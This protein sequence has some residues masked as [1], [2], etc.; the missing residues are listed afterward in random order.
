MHTYKRRPTRCLQPADIDNMCFKGAT[1]LVHIA[2]ENN[3]LSVVKWLLVNERTHTAH[4]RSEDGL[5]PYNLACRV[6]T[7]NMVELFQEEGA[8]VVDK[9]VQERSEWRQV[10]T[11]DAS[12]SSLARRS[13][14]QNAQRATQKREKRPKTREKRRILARVSRKQHILANLARNSVF[15]RSSLANSVFRSDALAHKPC[16][17]PI[18]SR[19]AFWRELL[20]L[21]LASLAGTSW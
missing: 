6:D 2:E 9:Y 7:G 14:N 21:T 4:H 3:S 1:N 19:S 10:E 15:W 20:S 17:P 8:K 11:R 5:T 16:S 13:F 18:Y 12:R